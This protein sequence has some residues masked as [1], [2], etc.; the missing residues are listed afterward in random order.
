MI[1][2]EI[3]KWL[4]REIPHASFER[5]LYENTDLVEAALGKD[6][7]FQLF[8]LDFRAVNGSDADAMR[9][10]LGNEL[11][12]SCLCPLMADRQCLPL[13]LYSLLGGFH[14]SFAK[15]LERTPWLSLVRC[16]RCGQ[17]WY[18]ACDTVDDAWYFERLDADGA[19]RILTTREWPSTF[20]GWQH[21]W[22]QGRRGW[23][24]S[25]PTRRISGRRRD[26]PLSVCDGAGHV[27]P[28]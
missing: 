16:R 28:A 25:C 14:A 23:A 8:E 6:L 7:A 22:P 12:R 2:V 3:W 1:P 5:W 15:L 17:N 18:A 20:D 13:S 26:R 19:N 11:P 9:Y 24:N 10:R 21:V 4:R 27:V